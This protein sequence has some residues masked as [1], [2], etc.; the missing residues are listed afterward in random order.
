MTEMHNQSTQYNINSIFNDIIILSTSFEHCRRAGALRDDI[1]I[2][3]A[4]DEDTTESIEGVP[5]GC[6]HC[7]VED[8]GG[9]GH[10]EAE[11][12]CPDFLARWHFHFRK[13]RYTSSTRLSRLS[14]RN[15][16][17]SLD[18]FHK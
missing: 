13:F 10:A 18:K 8:D 4:S 7:H 15:F 5:Q 6:H 12:E 9:G 17:S 11:Q 3:Q 1:V 2:N 16:G 14:W